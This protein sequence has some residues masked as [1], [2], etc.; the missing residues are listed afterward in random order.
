MN[1]ISLLLSGGV[2]ALS[3]CAIEAQP[4]YT[5][6]IPVDP[7]MDNTMAYLIDWDSSAKLDSTI[8][9]NSLISF[10]GNVEKPFLGRVIVNGNRGPIFIVEKGTISLDA[11]G[12]ASGTPLNEK[13]QSYFNKMQSLE[14]DY[15]AL[16]LN[17][18]IQKATGDSILAAYQAIPAEAFAENASTPVGLFWFLQGAY[19]MGLPEIDKAIASTPALGESKRVQSLRNALLA[20]AE[21]SEGKHYKDFEVTYDGKTEKLSDYVKPGRYTLVDFWASWCGPCIR[22]TKVIKELY[23]KYK[24]KGLDVVGV[25][26][27]DEVP[28]TLAAIKSHKLDWPCI[29]NAQT[30]PTDL[31][32][33]SGIPC[34][35]LINPEGIIVSRDKQSQ[36]LIDAVD[37]AMSTFELP[38][39]TASAV[40][41]TDAPA[42][43]AAI[44]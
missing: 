22:Q 3:A 5:V 13:L 44:F 40:T 38:A 41:T 42:D 12:N 31:Y 20:K 29:L 8:V 21:T 9:S 2:L 11:A 30:I 24:D 35:L 18:S 37:S 33:I 26:V 32:G 6:N 25:A 23:N 27:W 10:K 19:E 17:D 34:I 43:T 16:N 1:K 28:N 39:P 14:A 7:S 15:K 4:N 36:E